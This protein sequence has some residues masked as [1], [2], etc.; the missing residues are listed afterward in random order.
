MVCGVVYKLE[1]EDRAV[2]TV[3][4]LPSFRWGACWVL[5]MVP[6]RSREPP[7]GPSGVKLSGVV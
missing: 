2:V 5:E 3:L 7:S 4:E 6:D 1:L